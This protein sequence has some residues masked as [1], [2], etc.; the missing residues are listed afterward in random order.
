MIF[1]IYMIFIFYITYII[2]Y[3]IYMIYM[4]Y[5]MYMIYMIY[6]IYMICMMY[7]VICPRRGMLL[8]ENDIATIWGYRN[9]VINRTFWSEACCLYRSTRLQT[10][11]R[12]SRSRNASTEELPH[13]ISLEYR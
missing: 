12:V 6:I 4:M 3:M 5:M 7:I 13:R 2:L 10:A 1:I 11:Q 8:N 9:P